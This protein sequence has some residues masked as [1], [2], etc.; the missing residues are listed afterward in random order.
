MI[1]VNLTSGISKRK[2]TKNYTARQFLNLYGE[3]DVVEDMTKCDCTQLHESGFSP[4]NCDEE[5][6]EYTFEIEGEKEG[7]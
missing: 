3:E 5:W 6:N 2:I 1:K 7:E 4:C